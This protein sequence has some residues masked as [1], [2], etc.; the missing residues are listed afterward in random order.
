V[1]ELRLSALAALLE[2]R[3]LLLARTAPG[4]GD[5]APRADRAHPVIAAAASDP[6]ALDASDPVIAD[7]RYDTRRV[8]PGDVFVARRGQHADGHEFVSLAAAAGAAAVIVERPIERLGVPQ[9]VVRDTRNALGLAAAWLAGDPS[10]HLGV[11]GITGTDGKTTTAYLVRAILEAA[12]WPTGLLGTTDVI[13]GGEHLGNAA[14]TS[15]PEAPELQAHL[16]AMLEGGDRWAVIESTSHGLAQER[17]RGVAYDVAVLTNVT[18]EHLDFHG[19][20]EAYRAAKRS[21]FERLAVSEENPDKGWGKHALVNADDPESGPAAEIAARA[22]AAVLRYGLAG[23]MADRDASDLDI[24]ATALSESSAG[25]RIEMAT[26]AW[27]GTVP[28]RLAGR[29]NVHNAL[30]AMGVALALGLDLDASADALGGVAAVPGRM[31]RIDEGQAF[32]VII[33]YAHTAEALAKVLDE[34]DPGTGGGRTAVFGSAGDRDPSK[35]EPMGRAAGERCRLVII[36]DEDPR[37]EDRLAILEDIARG[38][39]AAG[40]RRGHD[41]LLIPDRSEAIATAM[42]QARPGDV[43]LVAG[44]GHERTIETADGEIPWD[45]VAAVRAALQALDQ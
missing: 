25:M 41:L 42:R 29:F 2:R 31:Q 40:R 36:T 30:A 32:R 1:S 8:R 11:V 20:L 43:V 26:P 16:A 14:R 37:T 27:R 5:A 23:T 38:A 12:G 19:T 33:D 6:T 9:L 4:G 17:V 44:K 18:S 10:L 7:M 35:R 15:T 13:V 45:E 22:G 24:A 34:I 39:E 28:L 21:L 3:G